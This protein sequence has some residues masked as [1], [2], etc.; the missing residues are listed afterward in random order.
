MVHHLDDGVST[1]TPTA[2]TIGARFAVPCYPGAVPVPVL[3]DPA[4][5]RGGPWRSA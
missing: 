3:D 1:R 5:M 4:G 2:P